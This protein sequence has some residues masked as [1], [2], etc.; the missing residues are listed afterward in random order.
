MLSCCH[1]LH[2]TACRWSASRAPRC[3]VP[4]AAYH[5]RSSVPCVRCFA[6]S[7]PAPTPQVVC[8][9]GATIDDSEMVEGLVLDHKA[10]EHQFVFHVPSVGAVCCAG[11]P[12]C[13]GEVVEGLVVDHTAGGLCCAA[14]S[15]SRWAVLRCLGLN[16]WAVLCCVAW[17]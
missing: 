17:L 9:P 16:Q 6:P 7:Y 3:A 8:K 10:G 1:A 5:V 11:C 4:V 15:E 2:A 12:V 13:G 14:W